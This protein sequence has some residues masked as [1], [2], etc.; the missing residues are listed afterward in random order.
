VGRKIAAWPFGRF[1]IAPDGLQVRLGFPWFTTR[2]AGKDAIT[3]VTLARTVTGPY[4]LRFEDATGRLADV[5]VHL[6]ARGR[7]ILDELLR[8]GYA[9]T[10]RKSRR[11]MPPAD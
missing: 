6:P 7:R 2:S 1:D 10:D 3:A 8:C 9:V 4:C 5:H 11:P